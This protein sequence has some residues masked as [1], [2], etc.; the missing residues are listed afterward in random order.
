[1][2]LHY[3]SGMERPVSMTEWIR[4]A[5][6]DGGKAIALIDVCQHC[7]GAR[8]AFWLGPPDPDQPGQS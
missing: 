4:Y 3:R 7:S 6:A 2:D 1:M 5:A 8:A